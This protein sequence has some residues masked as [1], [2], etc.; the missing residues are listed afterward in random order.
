ME[1]R[2][3]IGWKKASI[4]SRYLFLLL[5]LID[6]DWRQRAPASMSDNKRNNAAPYSCVKRVVLRKILHIYCWI[7]AFN[8]L[9]M[10]LLH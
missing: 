1:E 3:K 6:T 9:K 8:A 4:E 7:K 10:F 2:K 5:L